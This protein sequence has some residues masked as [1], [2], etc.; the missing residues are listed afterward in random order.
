MG[1]IRWLINYAIPI[2]CKNDQLTISSQFEI[3]CLN[4]KRFVW[5]PQA[6][7]MYCGIYIKIINFNFITMLYIC[8]SFR[9]NNEYSSSLLN[10]YCRIKKLPFIYS[11]LELIRRNNSQLL[12]IIFH[13]SRW[14]LVYSIEITPF[15]SKYS[16]RYAKLY[17]LDKITGDK[18]VRY[19]ANI[20]SIF[21][22][23]FSLLTLLEK[24]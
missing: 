17:L 18:I 19:E 3:R 7:A 21:I 6:L 20:T 13:G 5:W 14:I 2:C 8:W 15:K 9:A 23:S 11:T 10:Q 22:T 1:F 24:S 12:I 4:I 16:L